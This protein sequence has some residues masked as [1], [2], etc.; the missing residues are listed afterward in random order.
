[1]NKRLKKKKTKAY[2]EELNMQV[3]KQLLLGDLKEYEKTLF[4]A[5]MVEKCY[6]NGEYYF[7]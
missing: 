3:I 1:M 6:K 7:L 2:L 4:H 5:K